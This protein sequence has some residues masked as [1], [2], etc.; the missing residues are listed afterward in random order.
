M[1]LVRR[2]AWEGQLGCVR[3]TARLPC[4][5]SG[6]SAWLTSALSKNCCTPVDHWRVTGPRVLIANWGVLGQ[7]TLAQK[8]LVRDNWTCLSESKDIQFTMYQHLSRI[9][10]VYCHTT[11]SGHFKFR[12][13]TRGGTFSEATRNLWKTNI[14]LA[15]PI[16]PNQF[17]SSV[18]KVRLVAVT[19]VATILSALN[20]FVYQHPLGD[21]EWVLT[22]QWIK[23][24]HIV[25]FF[26]YDSQSCCGPSTM[27]H[28][29]CCPACLSACL[30]DS[31]VTLYSDLPL[32]LC[33]Y[34]ALVAT[35][36]KH[37]NTHQYTLHIILTKGLMARYILQFCGHCSVSV[38]CEN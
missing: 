29:H 3:K 6:P 7:S 15:F 12:V 28:H 11:S 24:L 26:S 16:S 4:D 14:C 5:P 20:C 17:A 36:Y 33:N 13:T 35:L 9:P 22:Q 21:A 19:S 1:S 38:Q 30:Y 31:D 25:L 37:I 2:R 10:S 23:G 8:D 18:N 32:Y 27:H 34:I